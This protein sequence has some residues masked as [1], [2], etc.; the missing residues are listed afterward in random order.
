LWLANKLSDYRKIHPELTVIYQPVLFDDKGDLAI[1]QQAISQIKQS[2]LPQIDLL[3]VNDVAMTTLT[4]Q[5]LASRSQVMTVGLQFSQHYQLGLSLEVSELQ[6]LQT[7]HYYFSLKPADNMVLVTK[8]KAT[9]SLPA[10][11]CTVSSVLASLLAKNY[12][13]VDALILA[14]GI[15]AQAI[16]QPHPLGNARD[17]VFQLSP[18]NGFND[19]PQCFSFKEFIAQSSQSNGANKQVY[20]ARTSSDC[21]TNLGL[22]IVAD[23]VADSIAKSVAW[24]NEILKLGVKSTTLLAYSDD[25]A[26]IERAVV[27]GIKLGRQYQARVFIAQHWQLAIKHAAYGIELTLAQCSQADFSAIK[28][29][30]L[31]LGIKVNSIYQALEALKLGPSYLVLGG[32]TSDEMAVEKLALITQLLKHRCVVVAT[33]SA[34]ISDIS[35]VQAAE[36]GGVVISTTALEPQGYSQQLRELLNQVGSGDPLTNCLN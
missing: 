21:A 25:K 17:N 30:E 8:H 18:V 24:L 32:V 20:S 16:Y 19:L 35:K 5:P 2:L 14:Q 29:A 26:E 13:Y 22:F 10:S 36:L 3:I 12:G 23:R 4:E 33:S 7:N 31:R 9:P 11:Q 27:Q 28:G 15:M 1:N 6:H 34:A